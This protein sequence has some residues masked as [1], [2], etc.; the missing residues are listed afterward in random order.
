MKSFKILFCSFNCF[1]NYFFRNTCRFSA[2]MVID[3][4]MP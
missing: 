4:S 1:P 2:L 3:S